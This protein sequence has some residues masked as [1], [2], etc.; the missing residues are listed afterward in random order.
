M[1]TVAIISALILSGAFSGILF[2]KYGPDAPFP[3]VLLA[4]MIL[5]A[6]AFRLFGK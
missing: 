4:G 5:T 6:A 1:K 2:R 3:A